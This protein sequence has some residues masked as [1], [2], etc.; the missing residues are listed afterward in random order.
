ML[1]EKCVT[2]KVRGRPLTYSK[3]NIQV[4][5]VPLLLFLF[6]LA[7]RVIAKLFAY[8]LLLYA[9]KTM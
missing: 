9:L 8:L 6:K 5:I 2:Y 7:C 1:H 3:F 4:Q